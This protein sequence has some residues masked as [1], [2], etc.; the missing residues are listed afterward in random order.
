MFKKAVNK[1]RIKGGSAVQA[2]ALGISGYEKDGG[3]IYVTDPNDPDNILYAEC[4][5]PFNLSYTDVNGKEIYLNFEDYCNA[6][7]T[8]ILDTSEELTDPEEYKMYQSYYIIDENGNKH[9]YK[10]KIE[11]D[12]PDILSV[13]AYRIPT[14]RAYSMINIRVKRFSPL[15]SGGTIRV[16]AQG[17]TIAGFD[18][19]IRLYWCH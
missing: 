5:I 19:D 4:E 2:S 6:D 11:V 1:Q 8:L 15:I 9:Y 3:L 17:T 7:G 14:E 13:I 12:Y 16:P 10:P 18:F